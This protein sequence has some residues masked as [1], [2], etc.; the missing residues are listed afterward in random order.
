V[1]IIRSI[2]AHEYEFEAAV[3]FEFIGLG[4]LRDRLQSMTLDCHR[5]LRVSTSNSTLYYR[6][7]TRACT[8]YGA[9][10]HDSTMEMSRLRPGACR[11]QTIFDLPRCRTLGTELDPSR[12]RAWRLRVNILEN[13]L[14]RKG[15]LAMG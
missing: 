9:P 1:D 2:T 3:A 10:S 14:G 5:C 7:T 8:V 13:I 6:D 11:S 15:N 12:V 4:L